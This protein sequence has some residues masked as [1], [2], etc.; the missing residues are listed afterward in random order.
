MWTLKRISIKSVFCVGI[1]RLLSLFLLTVIHNMVSA[2][3]NGGYRCNDSL[4]FLPCVLYTL[5][6]VCL[7]R[8]FLIACKCGQCRALCSLSLIC[9]NVCFN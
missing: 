9:D 2:K 3:P 8:V 7:L 4:Y 1:C 6:C 5:I